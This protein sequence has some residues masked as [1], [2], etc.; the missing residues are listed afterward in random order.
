MACFKAL[1]ELGPASHAWQR[2]IG[3]MATSQ[4][5]LAPGPWLSRRY[6]AKRALEEKRLQERARYERHLKWRS[7]FEPKR[8]AAT[9]R[10]G[11]VEW[12]PLAVLLGMLLGSWFGRR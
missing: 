3:I 10:R 1:S 7:Q 4:P 12:N 6:A 11:S 5:S 2:T 8:T 9:D